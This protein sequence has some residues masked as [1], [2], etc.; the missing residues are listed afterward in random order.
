MHISWRGNTC[1]MIDRKGKLCLSMEELLFSDLVL[2]RLRGAVCT[3][4]EDYFI[5][6]LRAGASLHKRVV[7]D[8]LELHAL[9]ENACAAICS[10]WRQLLTDRAENLQ[11]IGAPAQLSR[12]SAADSFVLMQ[13]AQKAKGE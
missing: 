6:E 7:L 4:T 12:R 1:L 8:L 5:E 9:S 11:I 10:A 2:L 13:A 3:Q